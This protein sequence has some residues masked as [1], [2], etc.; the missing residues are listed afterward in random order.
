M[1]PEIDIS[2]DRYNQI[3]DWIY[4]VKRG[5]FVSDLGAP[6]GASRAAGIWEVDGEPIVVYNKIDL[7]P[8][9]NKQ[10]F[11]FGAERKILLCTDKQ[12]QE[13]EQAGIIELGEVVK[14]GTNVPWVEAEKR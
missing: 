9:Q 13:L 5:K 8:D 12:A 1:A 3:T 10:N 11:G 6:L 7:V 2:F 14:T 4:K